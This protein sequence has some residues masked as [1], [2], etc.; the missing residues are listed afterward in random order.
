MVFGGFITSE[1]FRDIDVAI[2][3]GF[4]IPLEKEMEYC[5]ELSEALTEKVGIYVDVRLLDYAPPWFREE[6]LSK[7]Q[8]LIDRGIRSS[9]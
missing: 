6:A 7:C 8:V 9:D 3:T 5:E 4:S 1:L 2:F